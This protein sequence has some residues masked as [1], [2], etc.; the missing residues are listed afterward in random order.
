MSYWIAFAKTGDPNN[1]AGPRWP[2][3]TAT[4]ENLIDFSSEG[5]VVRQD[6]RAREL[7]WAESK[8]IKPSVW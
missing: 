2:V 3:F 1:A 4:D 5:P 8:L 7:D 6:F